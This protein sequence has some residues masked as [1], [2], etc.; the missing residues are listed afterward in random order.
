MSDWRGP[1][2]S[3]SAADPPR[4]GRS[5]SDVA[6]GVVAVATGL[7]ALLIPSPQERRLIVGALLAVSALCVA[8]LVLSYREQAQGVGVDRRGGVARPA[9]RS[10]RSR[11]PRALG[12]LTKRRVGEPSDGGGARELPST[13]TAVL[14]LGPLAPRPSSSAGQSACLVNRGS[15]FELLLGLHEIPSVPRDRGGGATRT[16]SQESAHSAKSP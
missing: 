12:I 3:G 16:R 2:S 8:L 5:R 7:V 1:G 4:P 10:A 13:A 14:R 6:L 9:R 15:G 11:G